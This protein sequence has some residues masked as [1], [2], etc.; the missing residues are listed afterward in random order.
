[1]PKKQKPKEKLNWIPVVGTESGLSIYSGQAALVMNNS[2]LKTSY[3]NGGIV[4][5][6]PGGIA[7]SLIVNSG[8]LVVEAGAIAE[9]VTMKKGTHLIVFTGGVVRDLIMWGEIGAQLYPG[10]VIEMM[11]SKAKNEA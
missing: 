2:F 9:Y 7:K 5:I 4:R 10:A 8:T 6:K 3:I 1:M 11:P